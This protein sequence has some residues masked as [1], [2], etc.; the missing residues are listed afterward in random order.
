MLATDAFMP[1]KHQLLSRNELPESRVMGN[2]YA[3]FGGGLREKDVYTHLAS[4]LPYSTCKRSVHRSASRA[5]AVVSEEPAA[6]V[7]DAT[8][9]RGRKDAIGPVGAV[10]FVATGTSWGA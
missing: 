1:E 2:Y 5:S 4:S 6:V 7:R 8:G 3:R 10:A 9:G